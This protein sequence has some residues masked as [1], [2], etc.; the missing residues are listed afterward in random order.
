MATVLRAGKEQKE[1]FS[2]PRDALMVQ[3][4][5]YGYAN[6]GAP[7][8]LANAVDDYPGVVGVYFHELFAYGLPWTSSFWLSPLQRRVARR[9]ARRVDFWMTNRNVSAHW[10]RRFAGDKPHAV[11]PVFSNVGESKTRPPTSARRIVVFGGSGQRLATYHATADYLFSW[12]RRQSLKVH[13]IGPLITNVEIAKTLRKNGVVQHGKLE[14]GQVSR[15]LTESAFGV[16]AYP[17]ESLARSGVF[18]AYCAHGVCPVLISQKYS[19]ADGLK[20]AIHY[21]SGIPTEP[22]SE[23]ERRKIGRAAWE[24][25]QPHGAGSHAATL[26]RLLEQAGDHGT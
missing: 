9:L 21:I 18:A 22:V 8:W 6:R 19:N 1:A 15:I 2:Q 11:L 24:W 13:D 7:V 26:R 10:L 17:V 12:A 16:S 5:G 4:S 25:Y 20:P 3:Y 23:L 14:A